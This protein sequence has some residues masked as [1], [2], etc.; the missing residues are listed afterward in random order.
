MHYISA[1]DRNG[2]NPYAIDLL[3]STYKDGL[4]MRKFEDALSVVPAKA[5]YTGS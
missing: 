4:V 5:Y 2:E 1:C 3:D